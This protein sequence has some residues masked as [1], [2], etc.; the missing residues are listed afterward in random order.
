MNRIAKTGVC[1]LCGRKYSHYGNNPQ[2]ILADS[3]RSVCDR[4]NERLV[5]PERVRIMRLTGRW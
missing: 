5:V 2:P 3:S 1:A 4:C